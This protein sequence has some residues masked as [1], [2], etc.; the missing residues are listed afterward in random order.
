MKKLFFAKMSGAGND[1][2][3]FD[4]VVNPDLMLDSNAIRR[5]CDRRNGI[6]ADGVI[7]IGD[8]DSYDFMME[9]FNSDGSTGSLCGNGARCAIKFAESTKRVKQHKASFISNG[10]SYVGEILNESQVKVFFNE[11]QNLKFNFKVKAAGQLINASFV[12]TG[13]PH[14]V[15]NATDVLK[16]PD[17]PRSFY[18]NI[19]E[20]PVFGIGREIRNLPEFLP[21]GT[22]VNF[23]HLKG[24]QVYIRTY[25]RGVEDETLACGTGNAATAIVINNIH[26]TA[27]PITLNTRGGDQ[28]IIDFESE[29]N[30]IKNLTLT[31]PVKTVFTGE[32]NSNNILN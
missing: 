19:N 16:N 3:V 2:I 10:K 24:D 25:E 30:S 29:H 32:I 27:P 17:N 5:L 28:L 20:V 1:F 13:S 14:V 18:E 4:K 9:Y 12:N 21:E 23:Y 7:T 6:G 11:P 15:I 31:G 8:S 22:N 26:K